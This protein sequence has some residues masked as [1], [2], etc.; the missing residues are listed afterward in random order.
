MNIF[1][2]GSISIKILDIQVIPLLES[3]IS[4]NSIVLVGDAFGTDKAVQQYLFQNNYQSV[5]VYYSTDKVR[6]NIGNWQTKQIN[7]ENHLTGKNL[8]QLKDTAMAMDADCGLMIW[9]GKSR[10]TKYN[11]EN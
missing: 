9:D 5:I 2:S 7:N 11:I 8:Y 4:N 10:G 1:I 3:I 6:N